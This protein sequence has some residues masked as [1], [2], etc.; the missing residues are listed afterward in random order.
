MR[1]TPDEEEWALCLK[2]LVEMEP[3]L[4]PLS[5]DYWYAQLAMDC[6]GDYERGI[7]RAHG[8]LAFVEE[9]DIVDTPQHGVRCVREFMDAFEGHLLHLSSE[10]GTPPKAVYDVSKN[11]RVDSP[12][13]LRGIYYIVQ[14]TTSDFAQIRLGVENCYEFENYDWTQASGPAW[15]QWKRFWDALGFWYPLNPRKITNVHT[16]TLANVFLTMAKKLHPPE[17]QQ[18][19]EF[20]HKF[21]H[22]P[23]LDL[24]YLNPDAETAKQRVLENARRALERRYANEASFSLGG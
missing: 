12:V 15:R 19:F 23:R 14:C 7:L 1:L 10:P 5:C 22:L 13:C 11:S 4:G 17:Q 16:G 8:R 18:K 3:G 24:L 21:H 2:E 9:F 6:K 20:G